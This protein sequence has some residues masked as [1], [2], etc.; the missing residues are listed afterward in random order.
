MNLNQFSKKENSS[1]CWDAAIESL[2]SKNT[3][4]YLTGLPA[5]LH[6]LGIWVSLN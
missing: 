1:T 4:V 6:P 5:Q 3:P 2:V